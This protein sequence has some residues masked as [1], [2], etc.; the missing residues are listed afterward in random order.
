[1]KVSLEQ[2]AGNLRVQVYGVC[3]MGVWQAIIPTCRQVEKASSSW[4]SQE[5]RICRDRGSKSRWSQI[6]SFSRRDFRRDPG[7]IEG[8]FE[9]M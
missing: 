7:R 5:L 6:Q 1:M 9:Q 2:R 8:Q 3:A 4:E